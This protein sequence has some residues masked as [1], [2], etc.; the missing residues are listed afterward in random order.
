MFI[1]SFLSISDSNLDSN[2]NFFKNDI[3]FFRLPCHISDGIISAKDKT[4]SLR[5]PFYDRAT[6]SDTR[7]LHG[8]RSSSTQF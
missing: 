2:R 4:V 3:L 7:V 5:S 6:A 8:E 1:Q